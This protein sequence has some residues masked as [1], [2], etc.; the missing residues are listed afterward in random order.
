MMEDEKVN[1]E[2]ILHISTVNHPW[3]RFFARNLDF[4][5]YLLLW[6][7]FSRLIL[8][9][10]INTL[11]FGAL[12]DSYITYGLMLLIEPVLLSTWGMTPGKAVFGLKIR[13]GHGKKLDLSTA[14]ARTWCVFTAGEGLN[15]PVYN[16]V[17]NYKCYR[18]CKNNEAIPWEEISSYTIADT[19]YYRRIIGVLGC[20][21]IIIL[22]YLTQLQ[23][24][25]PIH[26]GDITAKQYAQNCNNFINYHRYDI[27]VHMNEL[28]Q[29]IEDDRSQFVMN[30]GLGIVPT[31]E[32]TITDGKLTAV[33]IEVETIE[34]DIINGFQVQKLMA[35][36]S[37]VAAQKEENCLKI[38]SSDIMKLLPKSFDNYAVY[39][40][41]IR[42]RN[43]VE[44]S[45]YSKVDDVLLFPE[46]GK[47]HYFHMIFTLEKMDHGQ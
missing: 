13:D 16:L 32:L 23:A 21:G 47:E 29:W 26:R 4:L 27:G 30:I 25:M 9:W 37:L 45:G 38:K 35:V 28:G 24:E 39:E 2:F 17:R 33:R 18:M 6:V 11:R 20:L 41:G 14:F 36:M 1:D 7:A 19:M 31:H 8:R 3:L 10:N 15:I 22:S 42:I 43:E 5:I 12:L 44:Y 46:E 34:D 40:A